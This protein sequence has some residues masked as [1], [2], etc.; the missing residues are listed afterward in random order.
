MYNNN[1]HIFPNKGTTQ[2]TNDYP[3]VLGDGTNVELLSRIHTMQRDIFCRRLPAFIVS[4]RG[5]TN[6]SLLSTTLNQ[7][8]SVVA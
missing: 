8:L 3:N 5:F 4:G 7:K 2:I 1:K 6:C